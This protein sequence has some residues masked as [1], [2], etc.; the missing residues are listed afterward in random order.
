MKA[1]KSF[2]TLV[3]GG[4]SLIISHAFAQATDDKT[5]PPK[6][7]SKSIKNKDDMRAECRIKSNQQ[8]ISPSARGAFI[9]TCMEELEKK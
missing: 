1:N 3:L 9:K 4:L 6:E 5:A 2:A 7:S 8:M